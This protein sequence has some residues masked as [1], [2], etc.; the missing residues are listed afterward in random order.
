MR[1]SRGQRL[2]GCLIYFDHP[3]L[4]LRQWDWSR[5]DNEL[6]SRNL[7]P[8]HPWRCGT[9]I[10]L[11][12]QGQKPRPERLSYLTMASSLDTFWQVICPQN[13]SKQQGSCSHPNTF[14]PVNVFLEK[15]HVWTQ[16]MVGG[17]PSLW[18]P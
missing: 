3:Q 14:C 10:H 6:L 5:R 4:S 18:T 15:G 16:E 17:K 13:S 1:E 2:R 7:Q 12:L 11:R 9:Q 8:G